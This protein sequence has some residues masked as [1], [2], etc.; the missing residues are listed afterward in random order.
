MMLLVIKKLLGDGW[1]W[2]KRHWR[3]ILF[4]VGIMGF[5]LAG[6]QV[7]ERF[8]WDGPPPPPPDDDKT[9]VDIRNAM[10]ERDI[11]L[12]ELKKQHAQK[13]HELSEQQA[14]EFR[15]LEGKPIDEVV[16]WFDKLSS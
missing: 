6:R 15:E 9:V 8:D 16:A 10:A 13:M 2:V 5:L 12:E 4:P 11:L 3:W 1:A 7:V 14:R